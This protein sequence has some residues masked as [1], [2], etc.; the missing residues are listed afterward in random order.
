MQQILRRIAPYTLYIAFFQALIAMCSSLFLSLV[1][2]FT[3][4]TLCWYQRILMYPLVWILAAG[5]IQKNKK[6]YFY[7]LP[8]SV[9]GIIIALYHSLLQWGIIPEAITVC[10]AGVSCATKN[11]D[12]FGFITIPFLSLTAFAI[13]SL[14]L[15]LYK[16]Y[17]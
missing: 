14:S 17:V 7:V 13:I 5:I 2:H 15:F 1:L 16:K 3:P 8:L 4:C 12:F 6:I 11:I 9:L 10:T